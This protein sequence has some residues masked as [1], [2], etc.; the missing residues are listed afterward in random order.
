MLE[1]EF[2]PIGHTRKD[3]DQ[4]FSPS[5]YLIRHTSAIKLVDSRNELGQIY[6]DEITVNHLNRIVNWSGL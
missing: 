4:V 5:Y 1:V 3:I 6:N 2:L